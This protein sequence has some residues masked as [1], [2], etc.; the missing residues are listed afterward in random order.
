[1]QGNIYLISLGQM[2]EHMMIY[3]YIFNGSVVVDSNTDRMW[4]LLFVG[5]SELCTLVV[6]S[7]AS[8]LLFRLTGVG[9]RMRF[10]AFGLTHS[11]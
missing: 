5:V 3:L 10:A 4:H 1:M 6:Q 2:K 7:E 11:R 8:W 9:F